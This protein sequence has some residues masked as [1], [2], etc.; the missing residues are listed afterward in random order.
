MIAC[1]A[2][3]VSPATVLQPVVAQTQPKTPGPCRLVSEATIK[4]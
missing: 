1:L 2:L 4:K 3:A